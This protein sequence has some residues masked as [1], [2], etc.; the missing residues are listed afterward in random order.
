MNHPLATSFTPFTRSVIFSRF[1]VNVSR[2]LQFRLSRRTFDVLS[3]SSI[4]RFRVAPMFCV[5]DDT[6][7][8]GGRKRC[9]NRSVVRVRY[10]SSEAE[11]RLSHQDASTPTL[12]VCDNS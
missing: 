2:L 4:P 8:D 12:V 11:T 10:R 7:L 3:E 5:T 6:P 1:S 9:S